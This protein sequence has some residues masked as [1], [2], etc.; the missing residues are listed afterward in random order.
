MLDCLEKDG[1]KAPPNI[2]EPI[3]T[4]AINHPIPATIFQC[5]RDNFIVLSFRK[6]RW[7]GGAALKTISQITQL[8]KYL[9][10]IEP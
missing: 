10:S 5:L 4:I 3:G 8:P 7:I 9:A 1:N 6:W 2:P